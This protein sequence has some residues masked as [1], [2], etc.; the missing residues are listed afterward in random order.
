MEH[1][2]QWIPTILVDSYVYAV[3]VLKETGVPD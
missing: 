2:T 1:V 3:F